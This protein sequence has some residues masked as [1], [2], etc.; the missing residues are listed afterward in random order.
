MIDLQQVNFRRGER[1][2]LE[3]INLRINPG[4]QWVLLGRNGSGKTTLL[5]LITGY[6]FPS[7]GTVNVLGQQY[8]QCDVREVRRSIGYISQ[9]LL[10]KLTLRD[11]VWE[12]VATGLY[13]FLRFYQE[14]PEEAKTRAYARLEAMNLVRL[15][16]QPLGALSQGER[17]KILLARALMADPR[18]LIMDEP[19][20]G[21]DLYERERLLEELGQLDRDKITLIYVTHHVEEIVPVFTHAALIQEGRLLGSGLKSEM[22]TAERLSAVY[23][24]PVQVHWADSRPWITLNNGGVTL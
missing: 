15:A 20:S 3:G 9:S 22:V 24:L 11:P 23:G 19:C 6:Q 17:K 13:G 16:D 12:V 14:I 8:G 1:Q 5:E 21:L 2:I 10:E 4:E 7:S 18:L